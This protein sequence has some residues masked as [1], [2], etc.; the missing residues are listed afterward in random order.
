MWVN[1]V[2]GA[3]IVVLGL[4]SAWAGASGAF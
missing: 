3:A 1:R 4:A 2:S